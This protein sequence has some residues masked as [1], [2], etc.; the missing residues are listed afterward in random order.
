MKLEFPGAVPEI[1]VSDIDEAAAHSPCNGEVGCASNQGGAGKCRRPT[2][3][4]DVFHTSL[5]LSDTA[6]SA[7]RLNVQPQAARTR[8][9]WI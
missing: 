1:P 5:T 6:S 2:M 3:P 4:K 7:L 9:F 8:T